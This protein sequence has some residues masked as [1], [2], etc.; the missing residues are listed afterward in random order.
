MKRK[1][2]WILAGI[3]CLGLLE[4]IWM[5]AVPGAVEQVQ[6]EE[7][8]YPIE[9]IKE[10]VELDEN[11]KDDQGIYY[12]LYTNDHTAMVGKS[13]SMASNQS[14]YAG[15]NNGICII[16]EK[17]TFNGQEYVVT[18][19]SDRAFDGNLK[20]VTLVL[21]D[22]VKSIYQYAFSQSTLQYIYISS[23]VTSISTTAFVFADCVREIKVS[24]DNTKY[25]DLD[26]VLYTA[27]MKT[28][29]YNPPLKEGS[30]LVT[31][32]IPEGVE[33]IVGYGFSKAQYRHVIL[34][35][36]CKSIADYAF[37]MED[38]L[39]DIDLKNVTSIGNKAFTGCDNLRVVEMPDSEYTLEHDSFCEPDRLQ[40]LVL[41][42]GVNF[43][44]TAEPAFQICPEL[45]VL[46][47]EEGVT[48]IG[49]NEFR[50]CPKL[51]TVILPDTITI[52]KS[53]CFS[54][55]P[56][57][58]K[59][60][61]PS[62]VTLISSGVLSGNDTVIYGEKGS[63]A[64]SYATENGFEF[65][66]VSNHNHDN[67]TTKVLHESIYEKL[68][69]DYCDICGYGTNVVYEKKDNNS[70]VDGTKGQYDFSLE[71]TKQVKM[72]DANKMDD[73][74]VTY[75]LSTLGGYLSYTQRAS[76]I[77]MDDGTG[78][79]K[80]V[81]P[82][83]V[84]KDGQE[85]I[86]KALANNTFKGS[87]RVTSLAIPDT[88]TSIGDY[89]LASPSLRYLY[90]GAGVDTISKYAFGTYKVL[91]GIWVSP[92][93]LKY[94]VKNNVLYD[95]AGNVVY[96]FSASAETPTTTEKDTSSEQKNTTEKET[97]T[98][99]DSTT[100]KETSTEAGSNTEKTTSTEK[101]TTTEKETS[102]EKD[103][104][105]ETAAKPGKVGS[106]KVTTQNGK[107][108][109]ISWKKVKQ[110]DNYEIYRSNK[111]N[112]T[113]ECI[114]TEAANKTS[115]VDK[116]VKSYKKY[117]YK[118]RAVSKSN[119]KTQAGA[120][121]KTADF[122]VTGLKTP[123]ITIKKKK[124]SSGIHYLDVT[125]KNMNGTYI[126]LS[127]KRGNEKYKKVKLVS[128]RLSHYKGNMKIGYKSNGEKMWIRV[129]TYKKVKGKKYY[130]V[131]SNAVLIKS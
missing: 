12:T 40:S 101:S 130:S 51:E 109:I 4:N 78:K 70:I 63:I 95:A 15:A 26:G 122:T 91:K 28:L 29:Y 18:E 110:C 49:S 48:Q 27:D 7:Y 34:P 113:Y 33:N 43:P 13:A 36:S 65:V 68:S 61:I 44:T 104:T 96:D 56:K 47:V 129:R 92:G 57:L 115:Y 84:K 21:P 118:I 8:S 75:G 125:M 22:T 62:S 120:Y 41:K 38:S 23:G 106:V 121:S 52:L 127:V 50:K 76:T 128:N 20:I 31:Y 39:I 119:G 24:K 114:R 77:Q 10:V 98:E 54:T 11:H 72:L 17:V 79:S 37:W 103:T 35:S 74:G 124:T 90:I 102:V 6:A 3:L 86:V 108:V 117:Y 97:S 80:V 58:S 2:A 30:S 88:V 19:I 94:Y 112:G 25:V 87:E 9:D 32:E 46:V 131:Y 100:E 67:L 105:T 89:T 123:K 53:G 85:Y 71:Q 1:I 66:D 111:K 64:E 14:E 93:N 107:H 81:I 5:T 99:K 69:A 116:S 59:I 55:C 42:K 60:Y 73:Q 82:E 126:E 16:P 83:K 45:K